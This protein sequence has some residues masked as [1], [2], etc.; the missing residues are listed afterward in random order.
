[1]GEN[2]LYWKDPAPNSGRVLR[3]PRQTELVYEGHRPRL[4]R[5]ADGERLLRQKY[6]RVGLVLRSSR[7]QRVMIPDLQPRHLFF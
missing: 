2:G 4:R 6:L 7:L 5:P 3:A 1:V